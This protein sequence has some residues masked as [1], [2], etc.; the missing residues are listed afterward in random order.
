MGSGIYL[1]H[2]RM[3]SKKN[4]RI[5]YL[6]FVNLTYISKGNKPCRPNK[7]KIPSIGLN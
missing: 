7:N 3:D 6:E 4:I 5:L 2:F 1:P